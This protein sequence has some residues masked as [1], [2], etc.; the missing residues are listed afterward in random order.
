MRR[1][2]ANQLAVAIGVLIVIVS[3][4]FALIQGY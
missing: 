1:R 3:G 4:I 2:L